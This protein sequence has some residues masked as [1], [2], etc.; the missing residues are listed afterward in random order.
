MS[1]IFRTLGIILKRVLKKE[2]S[3]IQGRYNLAGAILI[4][5]IIIG[6]FLKHALFDIAN[7]F[8]A[9]YNRKL[10]PEPDPII[11]II[12]LAILGAYFLLCIAI[13]PDEE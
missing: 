2:T 13:L 8:L 3:S 1:H 7:F 11:L 10:L 6:Y 5:F 9:L 4:A 12:A